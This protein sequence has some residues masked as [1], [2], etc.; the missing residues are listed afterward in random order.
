MAFAR[1]LSGATRA[2][3]RRTGLPK[4]STSFE[5]GRGANSTSLGRGVVSPQLT[6][7]A[8]SESGTVVELVAFSHSWG[9]L[10]DHHAFSPIGN[11]HYGDTE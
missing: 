5:T 8:Q 1:S 2:L 4:F 3:R 11:A 10:Y 7:P 6:S 9:I